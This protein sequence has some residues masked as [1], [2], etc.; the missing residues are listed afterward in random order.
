[1]SDPK[2]THGGARA[3]AGRRAGIPNKAPSRSAL[4]QN[5]FSELVSEDLDEFYE[6]LRSIALNA[7]ERA[8]S[9]VMAVRELLDRGLGKSRETVEI[10]TP[11]D[12]TSPRAD[13]V[14]L[15]LA[16]P[17]ASPIVSFTADTE[18]P[19]LSDDDGPLFA[20]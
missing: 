4:A 14:A 19:G 1:M 9:R 7:E 13:L 12:A 8:S 15:W 10:V 5:R 3:G 2:N 18:G 11:E 6:V 16:T 17:S 20:E